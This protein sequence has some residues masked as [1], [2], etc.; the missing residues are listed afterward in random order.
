M[1]FNSRSNA[2]SQAGFTLVEILIAITLIAFMSFGI[3]QILGQTYSLRDKLLG[4]GDFYSEIRLAIGILDRDVAAVYYPPASRVPAAGAAPVD[5]TSLFGVAANDRSQ[6]WGPVVHRSGTRMPRFY[7]TPDVLQFIGASHTRV[8]Q[9]SPESI[10]SKI[11]YECKNGNLAKTERMAA[12]SLEEAERDAKREYPLLSSISRC[13]FRF[14]KRDR[15]QWSAN[16][17]G[18]RPETKDLVP[19]LIELDL[20]VTRPAGTGENARQQ[21]FAGKFLLKPEA[22]REGLYA[23]F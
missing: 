4:D 1:N 12:F 21:D 18:E 11:R 19:D 5:L 23:T 10:F 8:Y 6:Y 14:Y 17:D 3:Y 2:A 16:W 15:D 7:G 9:D 22:M 13:V 20:E